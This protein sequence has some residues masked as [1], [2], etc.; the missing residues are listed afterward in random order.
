MPTVR[1]PKC[2]SLHSGTAVSCECGYV[3]GSSKDDNSTLTVDSWFSRGWNTYK[4]NPR[5][6]IG[7][8]VTFT[9]AS[10]ISVF[11]PPPVSLLFT[12]VV[13]PSVLVGYLSLCLKLVRGQDADIF[14][15]LDGFSRFG[16]SVFTFLLYTLIV[17][18][19]SF[20]LVIPGVVWAVKYF[21]CLFAVLD[22]SLSA[23][24]SIRFSGKITNGYKFKLFTMGLVILLMI[25]LC[26]PLAL[27]LQ[28]VGANNGRSLMTVGII[29]YLVDVV[30]LGPWVTASMAAAYDSL[31][32]P[33]DRSAIG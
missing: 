27:G 28:G 10:L 2:H 18:A 13:L 17:T 31:A 9:V 20:L 3:F 15:I 21:P 6:I 25:L 14:N 1:C 8:S 5:V 12:Y 29:L 4:S 24:E 7:A 32:A 19:G 16:G 22:R 23:G 26:L 33:W 11:I 30:L